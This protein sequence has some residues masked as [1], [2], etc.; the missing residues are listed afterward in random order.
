METADIRKQTIKGFMKCSSCAHSM[1]MA[2]KDRHQTP[3]DEKL[4]KGVTGLAG[5]VATMGDICGMVNGAV[6]SLGKRLA[7]VYAKPEEEWKIAYLSHE[8]YRQTEIAVG[9]CSCGDIHGGKHLAKNF[10]RAI[11]TGK[12]LKC[13]EMLYKGSGI[14]DE[15]IAGIPYDP[16]YFSSPRAE[17]VCSRHE[18]FRE[19]QFHCCRSTLQDIQ[20]KSGRDLSFLQDAA[21]G[22]IG[23]IGFSG[24]LC[25][26][27]VGGILAAGAVHG[28]D[29]RKKDYGD[30][31]KLLYHGLLKSDK[32][33]TDSRIFKAA[34]T[35]E[36]SM[37]IYKLVE[38]SFGSCDCSTI[39]GLD[40]EKPETFS[41]YK[42]KAGIASCRSLVDRVVQETLSSL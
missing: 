41:A 23:G 28:V 2:S 10:R 31:L 20:D 18:H 16:A 30:T 11:L 35:Y 7:T 37:K 29:P 33:W 9:T 40:I 38:S 42:A 22:F 5:G 32:V 3:V 4:L 14:L 27:V 12:A 19:N 36:C 24:T 26:A 15:Q 13:I 34:K 17:E 1:V 8:F 6:V 21:T 39:T 25:G